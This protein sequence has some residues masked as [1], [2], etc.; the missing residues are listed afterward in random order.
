MARGQL[1]LVASMCEAWNHRGIY[2]SISI[3]IEDSDCMGADSLRVLVLSLFR[4]KKKILD[5]PGE[6]EGDW[7]YKDTHGDYCVMMMCSRRP[8][9]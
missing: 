6:Q 2:V 9:R 8:T 1:D 4:S 3:L 7:P 5:T